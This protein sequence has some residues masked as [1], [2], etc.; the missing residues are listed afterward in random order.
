MFQELCLLQDEYDD[1]LMKAGKAQADWDRIL[2]IEGIIRDRLFRFPCRSD[3]EG[4]D[5]QF[6]KDYAENEIALAAHVERIDAEI[7]AAAT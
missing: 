2:Q 4:D 5:V 1:L 3:Y 7:E 6:E